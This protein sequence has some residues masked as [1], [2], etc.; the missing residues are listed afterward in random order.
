MKLSRTALTLAAAVCLAAL[1]TPAS[2]APHPASGSA[3]DTHCVVVVDPLEPGQEVSEVAS[4]T[5][6]TG[7][8]AASR[9]DAS[10]ASTTASVELMTWATDHSYGGEYTHVYGSA[11]CDGAGYS[12]RPNSWWSSRLSSYLVSGGCNKSYASGP[13]GNGTFDGDVPYVGAA[14]NDAVTSIKIWRG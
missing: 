10:V 14:L 4:R 5:C 2:A 8:D 3:S 1:G 9:A 7:K 6:F 11:Y 12:F 13:R